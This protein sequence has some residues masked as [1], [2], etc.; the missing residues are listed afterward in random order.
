MFFICPNRHHRIFFLMVREP[1]IARTDLY[2]VSIAM[3]SRTF[4]KK[5]PTGLDLL[6]SQSVACRKSFDE[7]L[8]GASGQ[9]VGF[10]ET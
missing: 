10:L 4:S 6:T 3:V 2:K 9:N 8:I 7:R 5:L 1:F